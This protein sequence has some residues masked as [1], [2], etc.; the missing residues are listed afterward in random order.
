MMSSTII[1]QYQITDIGQRQTNK[2]NNTTQKT[3]TMTNTDTT[4]NPG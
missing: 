4:K 1:E 3:K 2:N